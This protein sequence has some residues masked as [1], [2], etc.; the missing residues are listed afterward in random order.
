MEDQ[1]SKPGRPPKFKAI[2]RN[3]NDN[4]TETPYDTKNHVEFVFDNPL[5]FKKIF[6]LF[7]IYNSKF[8][9]ME[10][11]KDKVIIKT[12]DRN[13]K[14][15]I[16]ID[17]DMKNCIHY[18]NKSDISIEFDTKSFH[19][20]TD[21]IHKTYNNISIIL[22]TKN[23][24]KFMLVKFFDTEINSDIITQFNCKSNDVRFPFSNDIFNATDY[25]LSFTLNCNYFKKTIA[26]LANITTDFVLRYIKGQPLLIVVESS[27]DNKTKSQIILSSDSVPITY[28]G[29]GLF[30]TSCK[31]G[32]INPLIQGLFGE[33]IKIYGHTHKNLIFEILVERNILMLINTEIN[34]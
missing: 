17:I 15:I 6:A 18:Y 23:L 19:T 16:N 4:I 13:A 30:T 27:T 14:S 24:N 3:E 2:I 11:L 33:S 22:E 20:I 1:H 21:T 7:K 28:N 32:Y 10:F 5:A 26:N 25:N 8:T 34:N 9:V 31:I 29:P 12:T